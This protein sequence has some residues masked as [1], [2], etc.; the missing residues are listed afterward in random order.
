MSNPGLARNDDDFVEEY[1]GADPKSSE[2][3]VNLVQVGDRL[4]AEISRRLRAEAG[5]S[6]RAL[7]LLAT[8][9]GLGGRATASELGQHVPI[10]SASITSLLDTCER[11]NLVVRRA[12]PDD[13]RKT[14]VFITQ[15]GYD[16]MD[17]LLPGMHQLEREVTDVLTDAEKVTLLTLLAKIQ[18]SV[19]AISAQ[20][21]ALE[22]A[23]RVRPSRMR[24][25]PVRTG[26]GSSIDQ[27]DRGEGSPA[28]RRSPRRG[29][30]TP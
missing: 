22:R 6:L 26:P 30:V 25:R 9:D 19:I 17:R 16:L 3:F 13:R 18:E 10:T 2:S 14:P 29:R 7:M 5:L 8:L 20:D 23:P 27:E 28:T 1:P 21:P 15:E 24:Y 12:D 11:K 4:D